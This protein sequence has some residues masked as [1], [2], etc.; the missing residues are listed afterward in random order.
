L[1][2][3]RY[4]VAIDVRKAHDAGIGT[5]IRNVVPRVLERLAGDVSCTAFVPTRS[6]E[7]WDWLHRPGLQ[8]RGVSSPP[9]GLA[10]QFELRRHLDAEALFWAT[11]LAHPVGRRGPMV[12]TVH[13]VAQLALGRSD[14]MTRRVVWAARQ[15]LASQ[16]SLAT[17]MLAVSDFTRREFLRLVGEPR[18]GAI[19]V[20]RLGVDPSWFDMA[21]IQRRPSAPY[22]ICVGSVRPHKNIGR[23][24][25]AFGRA[26]GRIPHELYVV[27]PLQSLPSTTQPRVRFTGFV[28][29]AALRGLVAGADALVFPSLYEGFGLP[30]LEAMAAGCPVLISN[31]ASLPEVCAD[32]AAGSFEPRSVEQ[33]E[34]ALLR[35]AAL[36]P[37]G[38][39]AIVERGIAHARTFDWDRTADLTAAVIERVVRGLPG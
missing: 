16:R 19:D 26:A 23:L 21:A 30:A 10:E 36:S 32:A 5:Y 20:T 1:S 11:S 31:N 37:Q 39:R 3:Y 24:L 9:L 27:G 22:F 15:M 34:G 17:A 6:T 12:A 2:L 28:E 13:D 35:H 7:V 33:I 8:V 25:Q 29:Q 14:G 4:R 38:R 18:C